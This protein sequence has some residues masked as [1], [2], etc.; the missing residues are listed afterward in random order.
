MN[1]I[2][3]VLNRLGV[4]RLVAR[5][6]GVPGL[7]EELPP[8]MVEMGIRPSSQASAAGE[9]RMMSKVEGEVRAA[10]LALGDKPLVVVT[11]DPARS[12]TPDSAIWFETQR[13]YLSLSSKSRLVKAEGSS[14]MVP[15]DKPAVVAEA[16]LE[17]VKA[18]RN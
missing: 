12:G 17:V 10:Q 16:I 1:R 9:Q 2:M 13:L 15:Y 3:P 14:H 6:G 18:T 5:L 7:R 4:V 11:S 8:G